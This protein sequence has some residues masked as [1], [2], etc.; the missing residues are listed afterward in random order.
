MNELR[1][2][3]TTEE[4]KEL[5]QSY[6]DR[7]NAVL[8]PAFGTDHCFVVDTVLAKQIE[9]LHHENEVYQEILLAYLTKY[10]VEN[11]TD[12]TIDL[13]RKAVTWSME[14]IKKDGMQ[15]D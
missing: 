14:N 12:I 1:T 10:P 3:V 5:G 8:L 4:F 13:I 2:I 6:F 15:N 9:K 7:Q 11:G